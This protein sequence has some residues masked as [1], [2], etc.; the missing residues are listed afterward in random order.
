MDAE[1][2]DWRA[3]NEVPRPKPGF[4]E[5]RSRSEFGQKVQSVE[6]GSSIFW[7]RLTDLTIV[8]VVIVDNTV[9]AVVVLECNKFMQ[10]YIVDGILYIDYPF[11]LYHD[12]KCLKFGPYNSTKCIP[13]FDNNPDE[14][15]IAVT[16][17]DTVSVG[18][19]KRNYISLKCNPNW[20]QRV[21]CDQ[22]F[23][24]C[25]VNNT[26]VMIGKHPYVL[27]DPVKGPISDIWTDIVNTEILPDRLNAIITADQAKLQVIRETAA[28]KY[29][30]DAERLKAEYLRAATLAR[31]DADRKIS[32]H[33]DAVRQKDARKNAAR[34]EDA[35]K[36]AVDMACVYAN[37]LEDA[38]K[39]VAR[40]ETSSQDAIFAA[41]LETARKE[42]ARLEA[43][44]AAR[45]E[46]SRK[47]AARLEVARLK[48]ANVQAAARQKEA[49]QEAARQEANIAAHLEAARL[50]ATRLEAAY[51][52]AD[53]Q[54]DARQKEERLEAAKAAIIAALML[55]YSEYN[56]T[57][58]AHL[59]AAEAVRRE[60]T[61]LEVSRYE[62]VCA[63]RLKDVEAARLEVSRLEAA[64]A[65]A[66]NSS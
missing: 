10:P 59:E 30:Q 23:R 4:P 38:R 41:R 39:E 33:R 52:A 6:E 1:S 43:E 26:I 12:R 62:A 31:L 27:S 15:I 18:V 29:S 3:V 16:P 47:E 56:A 48:A 34:Q 49:R 28:I 54:K 2:T 36:R 7:A 63:D 46:A 11:I 42:A 57:F 45:Q 65:A 24:W 35:Y 55:A 9:T 64:S 17:K 37:L 60:A 44:S 58:A 53:R 32:D 8:L 5:D 20:G 13:I 40:L 51:Q 21:Y 66:S 22:L 25:Q 19:K 61:R 50:K 14:H